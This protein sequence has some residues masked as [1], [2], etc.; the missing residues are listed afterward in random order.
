MNVQLT[1]YQS[2]QIFSLSQVAIT[3]YYRYQPGAAA[4]IDGGNL[5]A[6][7]G[8]SD[9]YRYYIQGSAL[10]VM[11]DLCRRSRQVVVAN[12][13][14]D[15]TNMMG[16]LFGKRQRFADQPG[17]ALAQRVVEPLDVIGLTG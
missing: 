17:H 10:H 14:L 11:L 12:E 8:E 7:N 3:L 1:R 9:G 13:Q 5:V 4:P 16:E 2:G 6:D 15:G